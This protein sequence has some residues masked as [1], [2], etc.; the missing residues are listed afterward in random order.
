MSVS[1]NKA[2]EAKTAA[3]RSEK[4][5]VKKYVNG[6]IA[7]WIIRLN[8]VV[9]LCTRRTYDDFIKFTS[10]IS[11]SDNFAVNLLISLAKGCL[12][13][14]LLSDDD[15]EKWVKALPKFAKLKKFDAVMSKI[16]CLEDDVNDSSVFYTMICE[17]CIKE[18]KAVAKANCKVKCYIH[19]GAQILKKELHLSDDE[20]K[21]LTN[22][23]I[24]RSC[25][26]FYELFDTADFDFERDD[27]IDTLSYMWN[28]DVDKLRDTGMTLYTYGLCD[29]ENSRLSSG[30]PSIT[31]GF[32]VPS[33]AHP[34]KK[35]FGVLDYAV[36]DSP[37][38]WYSDTYKGD[39]LDLDEFTLEKSQMQMLESLL[40][41]KK[42]SAANVLLYGA[43]GTGKT[44]LVYALAS[45]HKVSVFS[46]T[47][48]LTDDDSDRRA[49][50]FACVQIA[51]R[52]DNVLILVDE[53]ERLLSTSS[54]GGSRVKDKAWLN[55]F[56]EGTT[57]NIVWISNE[58]NHLND[59]VLRRFDFSVY[60]SYLDEKQQRN[61]W[62]RCLQKAGASDLLSKRDVTK[63]NRD[64]ER[65]PV[66][67]ISQS[68]GIAKSLCSGKKD[69]KEML[70]SQLEAYD[71]LRNGGV[72]LK[73]L[74]EEISKRADNK[75][76][77][78]QKI[79]NPDYTT[80]GVSFKDDFDKFMSR[81]KRLDTYLKSTPK[82][83]IKAGCGAMLFYG[84][85]GT[86]KS[87]L[88]RYIADKLGRKCIFKRASDLLNCFVGMT[89]KQIADCFEN[90][91]HK[92]EL[93]IIDEADSFLYSRSGSNRSWENSLVN[94]FLTQLERCKG[95]VVCTTNF[96][97]NLDIAV[98]RRF[99][100]KLEFD[101][102]G[103][104]QVVALYDKL[105]KPITKQELSDEDRRRLCKIRFLTPGDF[106][107]VQNNHNAVFLLD[108]D[109]LPS[110]RE[111]IDE[112]ENEIRL[113]N[114]DKVKER[115]I[116]F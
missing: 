51:K 90:L 70:I 22:F 20:V 61:I 109:D 84:A 52:L 1:A 64:F 72:E 115:H 27:N 21:Y 81:A 47:S 45:K 60:F 107:V 85:P 91:D 9:S 8:D 26:S 74:R 2:N 102:S 105:L 93:L 55:S 57:A 41:S 6:V 15:C 101:Y 3:I 18:F 44:S 111:L 5:L 38:K 103:P 59:A 37:L 31:N 76:S 88:A 71:S 14:Q 36:K 16:S 68:I 116:G 86:G 83:S 58:I 110:N 10:S 73:K 69:F 23:Y 11:M 40:C 114:E 95:M 43:P 33:L 54:M 89:E 42:S 77:E 87:E 19:Q 49:S 112:L 29:E 82:G 104:K 7:S 92:K 56:L 48:G 78:N 108:S 80:E 34:S 106:H 28:T 12:N 24:A 53:A 35:V 100:V 50:L 79:S 65:Y 25:Q 97:E 66:S 17:M 96:R 46:V 98:G 75:H 4:D 67:V 113:K 94:E 39:I 99:S 63:L 13:L 32:S 62:L 30:S